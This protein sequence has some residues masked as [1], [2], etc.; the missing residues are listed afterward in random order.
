MTLEK[1]FAPCDCY[2]VPQQFISG[3]TKLE[4]ERVSDAGTTTQPDHTLTKLTKH[5]T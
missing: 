4:N 3:S 5:T 2:Y 1:G